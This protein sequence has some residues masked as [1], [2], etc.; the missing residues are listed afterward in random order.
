MTMR[1]PC[2]ENYIFDVDRCTEITCFGNRK[3]HGKTGE[4]IRVVTVNR[5]NKKYFKR[6]MFVQCSRQMMNART[7]NSELNRL[8][9]S[10][11]NNTPMYGN[12]Y[13]RNYFECIRGY[14]HVCW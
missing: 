3:R 14:T 10:W 4:K 2:G 7:C 1:G 12:K 6:W 11:C 9:Y 5:P 8:R 13:D